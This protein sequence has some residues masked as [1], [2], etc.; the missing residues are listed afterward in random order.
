MDSCV[1]R[2]RIEGVH[3]VQTTD[4]FFPL[5]DDPYI[6]GK[7]GC[8]NVLS[9]LYAMGVSDCDNMLMLLAVSLEMSPEQRAVVTPLIIKGFNDLCR[10]AGCAVTGGQT[11]KNPWVIVGGVASTVCRPTDYILPESAAV[12]DVLVLTKPLG[13]Q[14][15]VNAHQWLGRESFDKIRD[16]LTEQEVV[17]AYN[18]AMHSMARLNRNGAKLMH[19]YGSKGATDVTGFGY[20]GHATNLARNQKAEVDFELDVLPVIKHTVAVASKTAFKLREGLSAETSGGL[21]VVLPADQAKAFCEEL[22][23]LDGVPAWIVGR[24]V[25]GTRTARIMPDAVMMEVSTPQLA[26]KR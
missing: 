13:T 8:A 7:I 1:M 11:V 24:V 5:V 16:V 12:G 18:M 26:Y 25:P 14:L 3:L 21:L 10:E 9:D 22:E 23:M 19:K 20:L 15:C 2:T 17:E 6:Q 4:F